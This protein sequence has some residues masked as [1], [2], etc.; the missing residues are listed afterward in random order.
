MNP[1]GT[2]SV[3]TSDWGQMFRDIVAKGA[4][5]YFD[6]QAVNNLY[7]NGNGGYQ[8]SPDGVLYDI[9]S[10]T[11]TAG[12]VSGQGGIPPLF[13]LIGAGVLIYLLAKE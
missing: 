13:L 10:P 4:S 11:L 8:L 3:S 7:K 1:D 5:T 9:G 2:S 12:N 6:T